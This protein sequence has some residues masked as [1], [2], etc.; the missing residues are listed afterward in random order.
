MF[1][2]TFE[3][4]IDNAVTESW[5]IYDPHCL[6]LQF[7]LSYI[8]DFVA[9]THYQPLLVSWAILDRLLVNLSLEGFLQPNITNL[10]QQRGNNTMM[11]TV[12]GITGTSLNLKLS[13]NGS[14]NCRNR[15]L[16][17]NLT[18]FSIWNGLLSQYVQP[19]EMRTGF[20]TPYD[21]QECVLQ[22]FLVDIVHGLE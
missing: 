13:C 17:L 19:C 5:F 11:H 18:T 1:L 9:S 6:V 4:E 16:I 12:K 21:V 20:P 8:L 22:T 2:K 14:Q 7:D 15:E 10:P 3:A